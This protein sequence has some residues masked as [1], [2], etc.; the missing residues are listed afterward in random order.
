[1]PIPNLL[2]L[3]QRWRRGRP[4]IVWGLRASAL[5]LARYDR[6]TR[7]SY[8]LEARLARFA[9]LIISNSQAGLA[10]A[11]EAGFPKERM[12]A[13]PNGIDRARFRPDPAL[14]AAARQRWSVRPGEFVV[15]AIG[16]IDPMKDFGSFLRAFAA[17]AKERDGMRAVVLAAGGEDERA[18]LRRQAEELGMSGRLMLAEP[19]ADVAEVLNGLDLYCSTSAYGEGFPNTVAEAMACGL[20]CVVTA[21][22]DSAELVGSAGTVVP[23]R[24]PKSTAAAIL[25]L[26]KLDEAAR[27][28]IGNRLLARAAEF[29]PEKLVSRTEEALRRLLVARSA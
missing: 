7:W 14:R 15:G 9:D 27:Q 12:I 17:A 1:L 3:S 28:E 8:R 21:V 20:P 16:R 13:I 22:G 29:T 4:R 23:P 6:I 19:N 26:A 10:Q 5:E 11:A 25:S 2:A 24:D 18:G